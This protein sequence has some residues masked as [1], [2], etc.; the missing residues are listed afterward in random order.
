[1]VTALHGGRLTQRDDRGGASRLACFVDRVHV[2][3]L[4]ERSS[5]GLDNLADLLQKVLGHT[6]FVAAGRLYLPGDGKASA[7]ANPRVQLVPVKPAALSSRDGGTVAP[8]SIR[9]G[10]PL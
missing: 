3:A 4:V 8:G 9:V 1:M 7:R 2:V 5:L 10:E 6:R